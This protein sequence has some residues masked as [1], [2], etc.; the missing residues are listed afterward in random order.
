MEGVL[1]VKEFGFVSAGQNLSNLA[2]RYEK[3]K[4]HKV[5]YTA[6]Q[7]LGNFYVAC[8]LD[9]ARQRDVAGHNRSATWVNNRILKMIRIRD[10]IL[11][12]LM[13]QQTPDNLKLYKKFRNRV[14]NELKESKARYFH[15]YFTTNSQNMKKLWSGIKTIISHKSSTSSSIDKIKGKDRSF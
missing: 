15:D 6:Y 9:E 12:K 8:V 5:N 11:H 10:R 13:K 3:S 4:T 7:L 14:S 1:F 2:K